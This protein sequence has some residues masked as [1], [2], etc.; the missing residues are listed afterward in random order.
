GF[1][2]AARA[3]ARGRRMPGATRRDGG[4]GTDSPGGPHGAARPSFFALERANP[5]N[6]S[7]QGERPDPAPADAAP[8]HADHDG[9]LRQRGSRPAGRHQGFEGRRP[10]VF[11]NPA[12]F[13][14]TGGGVGVSRKDYRT[15]P[16]PPAPP[17][18]G[19]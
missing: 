15:K 4:K 3:A 1:V 5:P 17:L 8:V 9:L 6:P 13:E 10:N 2:D 14:G 7:R 18:P 16:L 12:G 19:E 11:P